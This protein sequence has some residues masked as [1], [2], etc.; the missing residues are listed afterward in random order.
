MEKKYNKKIRTIIALLSISF[1][2]LVGS[3]LAYYSSNTTFE[4]VFNTGKYKVT[5]TEEFVSPENWVPGEEIPKTITTENKGTIDAAVR[6]KFQEKWEN[7]EGVDITNQVTADSV[8]INFDNVNDWV[9]QGDYYYY[10]YPLKPGET[11]SSFI[12]SVTLNQNINDVICTGEGSTKVCESTNPV[13]GA[14]YKLTITKETVQYSAYQSVWQNT[15]EIAERTILTYVNRQTPNQV[16]FGDEICIS[17][18]CFNVITSDANNIVMLAKYNLNIGSNKNPATTEG[19]QDQTLADEYGDILF[20]PQGTIR[21]T[22]PGVREDIYNKLDNTSNDNISYYIEQ[23]VNKLKT[24]APSLDITGRL[25]TYSEAEDIFGCDTSNGTCPANTFFTT[26]KY[27]M[28][29]SP[30]D[31]IIF[32]MSNGVYETQSYITAVK[33]GVRPV[34]TIPTSSIS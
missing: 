31:D 12:K 17:T 10:K 3:T 11:T 16:T 8:I 7:S 13:S 9:R 33:L 4:N 19:L 21:L 15:P 26:T 25:V 24:F 18:E 30:A 34:I 23:Y 27:W 22:T 5:T 28:G 6:V 20:A 32:Y 2:V 14:I 29:T 1:G